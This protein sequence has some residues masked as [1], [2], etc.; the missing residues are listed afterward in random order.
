[1]HIKVG[2]CGFCISKKKYYSLFNVVE[3]QNTFYKIISTKLASSWR[4]ESPEGFEFVPKAWMALTHDPSSTFWRKKGL[5]TGKNVGLLRCSEDNFRLW[6]EFLESIKPLNP[7]LVI[8]Q[9]PPSF[10][11]TDEN[12]ESAYKFFEFVRGDIEKIGWEVR[13]ESWKGKID[14]ILRELDV[15]HVV[16]PLYDVPVLIGKTSYFRLHGGR[17]KGKIVYKYKY[18]DEE[19]SRLV[20]FVS[21]LSSEVSYV[22]FNNSYMGEDSQR[23]LNMLRSID[24]TSPPRSSSPM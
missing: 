12:V 9:S 14:G 6:K 24:T 17:E 16:D 23:F 10:E 1:M 15:I 20:R 7:K 22:M 18:G 2:C 11:A 5:P 19:I 4:K 21:G 13:H 8:F 3:V